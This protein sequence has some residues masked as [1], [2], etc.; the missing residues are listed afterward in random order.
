MHRTHRS[1]LRIALAQ[2]ASA[3]CLAALVACG[4]S[5]GDEAR[6]DDPFGLA[7]LAAAV[8]EPTPPAPAELAIP[9]LNLRVD[10]PA[11]SSVTELLGSQMISGVGLVVSVE[12]ANAASPATLAAARTEADLFTPQNLREETLA[13]GWVLTYENTGGM[14]TNYFVTARRE[15]GGT[16]YMCTT[17]VSSA[18][19]QSA[20]VAACRS[21]RR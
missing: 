12:A 13:D 18:E 10:A 7:D 14:G 15:I 21:L 9:A 20:A 6:N 8:A 3:A 5:D 2:L 11:G 4:G 16:A 17:T 19:Q 1:P